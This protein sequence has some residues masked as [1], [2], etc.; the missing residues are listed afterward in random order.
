MPSYTIQ[1]LNGIPYLVLKDDGINIS[2]LKFPHDMEI[3]LDNSNY[4]S[5]LLVKGNNNTQVLGS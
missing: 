4:N 3:G 5:N 1:E 2:R